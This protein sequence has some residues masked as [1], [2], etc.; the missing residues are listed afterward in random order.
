MAF[1]NQPFQF[2]CLALVLILGFCANQVLARPLDHHKALSLRERHELWMARH[3]RVYKD[4]IEKEKRFN[5]FKKNVERI[6]NFNANA[7]SIKLYTLG[8]NAFSDLTT[9]EFVAT[10]TGYKKRSHSTFGGSVTTRFRYENLTDADITPSMDWREFGAVTGIKNQGSCGCCWAFSAV[11]AIEGLNQIKT[12]QLISLSEEELVDCVQP[13]NGCAGAA[14]QAAFEFIRNNQGISKEDDYPYTATNGVPSQ[15]QPKTSAVSINGFESI[16]PNDETALM[17]AVS[18]QPVA[19]G[20]DGSGFDFLQYQSGVF[21]GECGNDI[22]H[23]V[24]AIGY[25]TSTDG[26]DYWLVKN[27]WGESWGE[28]G[29]MRIIRG[30]NKCGLTLDAS[31]PV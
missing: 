29:Y 26:I 23:A 3:G 19:V 22:T 21:H 5:I 7:S 1:A 6:E 30:Q 13:P 18:N 17:K 25:G 31:Y 24:T 12:R 15:C 14:M 11:G 4:V 2:L 27:S 10:H 8:T 9:E 16:P 28:N 20:L